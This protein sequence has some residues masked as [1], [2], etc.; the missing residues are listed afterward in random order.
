MVTRRRVAAIALVV[1]LLLLAVAFVITRQSKPPVVAGKPKTIIS[2]AFPVPGGA[3]LDGYRV[4]STDLGID[5]PLV[6][7][8]GWT[9]PFYKAALFPG[10]ETPGNGGR[11]ML[12]AHAQAGMFAPLANARTGQKVDVIRPGKPV[13]HYEIKQVFPR[14]SPGDLTYTK[15]TDHEELVLLTC[16]SYEPNDPRIL[17]VAE[18]VTS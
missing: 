3:A 5:L 18:P 10:M 12:Y 11:A 6:N 8:D 16:T 13:L 2:P 14:W 15:P 9:V 17:A 1:G 4:K 7:G